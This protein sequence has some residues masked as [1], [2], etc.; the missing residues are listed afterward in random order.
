MCDFRILFKINGIVNLDK[1]KSVV[2]KCQVLHV[3]CWLCHCFLLVIGYQT[4][5]DRERDW[6]CFNLIILW[7]FIAEK[8]VEKTKSQVNPSSSKNVM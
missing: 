7:D 8:I 6:I 3:K 5:S 4:E 1:F 2:I